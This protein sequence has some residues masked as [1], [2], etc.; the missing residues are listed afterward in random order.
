MYVI[1]VTVRGLVPF[2]QVVG[3]QGKY[4]KQFLETDAAPLARG[5]CLGGTVR[6]RTGHYGDH[7]WHGNR[8]IRLHSAG[9]NDHG[10]QRGDGGRF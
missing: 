5:G 1:N 9:S 7:S 3:S 10:H 4:E 8:L 6:H 2:H